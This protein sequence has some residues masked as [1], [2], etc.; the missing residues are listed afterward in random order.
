MSTTCTI[1]SRS[2]NAYLKHTDKNLVCGNL[3]FDGPNPDQDANFVL[4]SI[5]D[6]IWLHIQSC[7]NGRY[8]KKRDDGWLSPDVDEDQGDE[9][10]K[11]NVD[12]EGKLVRFLHHQLNTFAYARRVGKS[13]DQTIGFYVDKENHSDQ[14]PQ[15]IMQISEITKLTDFPV[16]VEE[17]TSEVRENK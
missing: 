9:F 7:H 16:S 14:R 13:N 2:F 10:Q 1:E 4:K 17:T 12:G 6:S 5:P 8:L 3:C 15:S 11:I